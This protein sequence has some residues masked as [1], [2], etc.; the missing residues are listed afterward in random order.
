MRVAGLASRVAAVLFGVAVVASGCGGTQGAATG[1]SDLVPASAPVYVAIDTDP[2]SSQWRT[3]DELAGRFPDEQKGVDALKRELKQQGELDW[4]RDVK[5]ALGK[6]I[7]LVWLDLADN[8]Q[9]LVA[10]MQPKDE[11]KFKQLVAKANRKD[12]SNTAVYDKFHGWEVIADKQATIDRFE[13]AS[14]SRTSNLTDEPAFRHSMDRLGG[15][16]IV[17]AYVSGAPLM[18]LARRY[19]GPSDRSFITKAGTLDWIALR[20]AAKQSGIGLD[21]IVHGTPGSLFRGVG[22][23]TSYSAKL[24]G[25]VPQNALVYWTFHGTKNMFSGLE[26]N[27]LLRSPQLRRFS[28]VLRQ[29]G[30]LLQ[31]ENAFYL[32]PSAGSLPEVTFVAAPGRGSDGAGILDGLLARYRAQLRVAPQHVTVAGTP[33]RKLGFGTAAAYYAN[34]GGKLV[35]TDLPAGIR[36]VQNAGTPLSQNHNY[37]DATSSSGLPAQSHGFLYV[38]I[39]STIPFVEKLS[40]AHLPPSVSRN[41]EPLRSAVEYAVSHSHELQVTLFLRIK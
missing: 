6:E 33:T 25:Q 16:A 30:S 14:D 36:G 21:T 41:L 17:R 12:P 38:D 2:A 29:I 28:G 40:H 23:S 4:E 19:S 37:R 8:G 9:D 32:R 31:G 27:P 24:P 13:R 26:S 18:R 10:L 7:D 15:D 11:G 3:V 20:L 35:V 34:V 22:Q 1:A 5:P 39:H